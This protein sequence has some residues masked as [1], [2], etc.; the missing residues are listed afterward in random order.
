MLAVPQPLC[1]SQLRITLGMILLGW[2][3]KLRVMIVLALLEVVFFGKGMTSDG[4][5]DTPA[6]ISLSPRSSGILLSGLLLSLCL[7][8]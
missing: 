7:Y 5:K 8:L 2:L 3:I 6:T 4:V 1:F